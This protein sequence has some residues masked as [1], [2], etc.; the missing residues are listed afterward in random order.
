MLLQVFY[1][2]YRC[3]RS[4]ARTS[5]G[6]KCRMPLTSDPRFRRIGAG[7]GASVYCANGQD[8]PHVTRHTTLGC[9]F[10]P[11]MAPCKHQ[12]NR[13]DRETEPRSGCISLHK[14]S[15]HAPIFVVE[16]GVASFTGFLYLQTEDRKPTSFLASVC[17]FV[18][19][20]YRGLTSRTL[21]D[22]LNSNC[23]SNS[24]PPGVPF[25]NTLKISLF[26]PDQESASKYT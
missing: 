21:P 8:A 11:Y 3:Q 16:S 18:S 1:A 23:R 15:R 14:A 4:R 9:N 19:C 25:P 17:S 10:S 2:R 20:A 13:I 22:T 24:L 12:C 7:K 26:D 6:C 5:R